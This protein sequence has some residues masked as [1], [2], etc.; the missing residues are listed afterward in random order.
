MIMAFFY[1]HVAAAA[2]RAAEPAKISKEAKTV[3]TY[4]VKKIYMCLQRLA[5]R[6]IIL[7]RRPRQKLLLINQ[8]AKLFLRTE[9]IKKGVST[10]HGWLVQ[11]RRRGKSG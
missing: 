4:R 1:G 5:H 6:Q 8:E 3:S 9:F 7:L 10:A 2:A 11:L